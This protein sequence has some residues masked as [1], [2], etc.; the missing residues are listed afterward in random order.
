MTPAGDEPAPADAHAEPLARVLAALRARSRLDLAVYGLV[1]L[2]LLI[3][4]VGPTLAAVL[5]PRL[6]L[7]LMYEQERPEDAWGTR[8]VYVDGLPRSLGPDRLD[9]DGQGDDLVLLPS[10]GLRMQLFRG[11]AEALFGLAVVMAFLWELVRALAGQLRGPRGPLATEVG[12]AALLSLAVTPLV[13]LL[14]AIGSHLVPHAGLDAMLADLR[15][16]LLVPLELAL[17]GTVYLV[18][19]AVLLGV[20]LRAEDAPS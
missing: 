5:D 9:E 12:R 13:L 15:L 11:G 18:T 19:T 1:G 8:W 16:R 10:D 6:T 3:A 7:T 17:A 20:R 2:L 14:L 4:L